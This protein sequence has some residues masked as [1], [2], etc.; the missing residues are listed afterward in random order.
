MLFS[1][2]TFTDEQLLL[3]LV[4]LINDIVYSVRE[5]VCINLA[6]YWPRLGLRDNNSV[7]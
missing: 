4:L 2:F 1:P 5:I 7:L 3:N 6:I